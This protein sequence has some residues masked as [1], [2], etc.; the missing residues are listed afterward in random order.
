MKEED[1]NGKGITKY[2]AVELEDKE[3][4]E[5]QPRKQ[6]IRPPSESVNITVS[7]ERKRSQAPVINEAVETP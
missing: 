6:P 4:N 3:I 2:R 5:L 1:R 7:V